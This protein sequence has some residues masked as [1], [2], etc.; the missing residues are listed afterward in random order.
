MSDEAVCQSVPNRSI[1][2]GF[3]RISLGTSPEGHTVVHVRKLDFLEN[4][5]AA[6]YTVE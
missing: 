4:L 3:V 1:D 5:R 6:L 2:E